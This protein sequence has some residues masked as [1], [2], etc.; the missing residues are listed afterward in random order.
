MEALTSGQ[1][2]RMEQPLGQKPSSS[3]GVENAVASWSAE[4]A[5]A[6][7]WRDSVPSGACW[8]IPAAVH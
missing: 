5:A 7:S 2:C 3:A 6:A 4:V 8:A 1:Q